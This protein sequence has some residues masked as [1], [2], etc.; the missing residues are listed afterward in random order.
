MDRRKAWKAL[1]AP[2][3]RRA[4]QLRTIER[5]QRMGEYLPGSPEFASRQLHNTRDGGKLISIRYFNLNHG[6][7]CNKLAATRLTLTEMRAAEREG[8]CPVMWKLSRP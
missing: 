4:R 5:E 2:L 3:I 8:Q 7:T 6:D 1:R